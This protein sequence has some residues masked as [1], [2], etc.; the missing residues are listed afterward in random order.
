MLVRLLRLLRLEAALL[1]YRLLRHL[2]LPHFHPSPALLVSPSPSR[3]LYL[4]GNS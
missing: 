4:F 2:I 3:L 1:F